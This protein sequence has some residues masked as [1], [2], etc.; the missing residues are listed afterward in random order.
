MTERRGHRHLQRRTMA[1]ELADNLTEDILAG[2]FKAGEPIPTEPELADLFGV[3]RSVVRDAT[4]VLATRGLV[5]VQHGRG[6]FVTTSPMAAFSDSL[7]LALRRERA[8]AW[9][10]EE[11]SRIVWPEVLAMAARNATE[12]DLVRIRVAAERY[13]TVAE[14]DAR[15]AA[16][17]VR[18]V[19]AGGDEPVTREFSESLAE[20]LDTIFAATHNKV[21]ALLSPALR[22]IRS[23][24]HWKDDPAGVDVDMAFEKA[25]ILEVVD[26]LES[27]DAARA[28][29]EASYWFSLPPV[30][31]EA[32]RRTEVGETV[33]IP[34]AL[35][36]HFRAKRRP[37]SRTGE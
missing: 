33:K 7:R 23:L 19:S 35:A 3:S 11:F 4:R 9:D 36:E 20:Y 29:R 21:F 24:R 31:I 2:R 28:R 6:A 37:T 14:R 12:D 34:I 5:D 22:S 25:S 16:T 10:V 18:V 1:E 15:D 32:M 8:T 26:A 17:A 27:R 13:I 30:A